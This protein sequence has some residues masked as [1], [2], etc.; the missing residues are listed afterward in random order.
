VIETSCG[1]ADRVKPGARLCE[2]NYVVD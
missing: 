1:A 2:G